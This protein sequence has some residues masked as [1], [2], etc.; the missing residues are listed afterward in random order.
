MSTRPAIP[1]ALPDNPAAPKQK[2]YTYRAGGS[3]YRMTTTTKSGAGVSRYLRLYRVLSQALADGQFPP[4]EPLLSEP[5]LMQ[6]YD[7]SRS[8]VRRALAQLETEGRIE[9]KRGSG[10]FARQQKRQA[11]ASRDFSRILDDTAA[12][13]PAAATSRTIA[14]RRLAAPSFLRDEQPGLGETVLLIRRIRYIG[15]EPIVLES[16]YL[17]EEIGGGL[18]RRQFGTDS[19]GILKVLAA[20]GHESASMEREFAALEADPLAAESLDLAIGEPVFNVRT[21]ARDRRQRIL[22]YVDCLYRPDRYEAH[23]AIEISD[24]WRRRGRRER[25]N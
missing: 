18:T 15:R 22:A 13:R 20:H 10:T 8:T 21:L 1:A 7:I 11:A 19:G 6:R 9:R 5:Q 16:A 23:A 4:G 24:A 12:A 25:Q 17:P 3:L 14:T 2:V